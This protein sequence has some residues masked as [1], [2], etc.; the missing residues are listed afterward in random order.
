MRVLYSLFAIAGLLLATGAPA[1]D[2]L[3]EPKLGDNGLHIQSWFHEGF[4]ELEDDLATA[5]DEGKDLLILVEQ[6]GCP[7]CRE[8][9]QVNLRIPQIVEYI[10]ENFQVVQLDM[11]G[12]REVTDMD[13]TATEERTLVRDW[14]VNFTPTLI[15]VPKEAI[16]GSGNAKERAV[17]VMP[18][19][20]K[21]FHFDTMMHFI[22]D[23]SYRNGGDFQ[24]YLDDRAATLRAEGKDVDIW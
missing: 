24:R 18:G 13:G 1:E 5:A 21:P 20:F 7:Y 9:H 4:L 16:D 12:S 23:D 15:F 3:P 22:A 8:M 19:Y 17:M 11:R 14:G 2:R 10:Q 6:P